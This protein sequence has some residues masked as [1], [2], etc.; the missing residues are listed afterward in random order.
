M[1]EGEKS[2]HEVIHSQFPIDAVIVSQSY[3][4]SSIL[5][6]KIQKILL[7]VS[8]KDYAKLSQFSTPPGILAV[9]AFPKPL[10]ANEQLSSVFLC[11]DGIKDPGNLGTILR[12]ADW[13]GI[14]KVYL[15]MDCVDIYNHKVIQASM[16]SFLRVRTEYVNLQDWLA[17][18]PNIAAAVL[19]GENLGNEN[20]RKPLYLVMGSESHGINQ[21]LLPK[22]A[23]K[24][25]I[26]AVGKAESLNVAVATGILLFHFTLGNRN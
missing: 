8:D 23:H 14:N 17:D 2:V 12:T 25:S 10:Q 3:K 16:G 9:V 13:F 5:P 1:V 4:H 21:E 6:E 20:F 11:L 19:G 15:S 18:K 22:H 7:V 24:V 26:P